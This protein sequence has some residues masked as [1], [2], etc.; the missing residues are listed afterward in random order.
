MPGVNK[1]QNLSHKVNDKFT[2]ILPMKYE[3]S[4]GNNKS[5]HVFTDEDFFRY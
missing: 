5:L 4:S 1:K 3:K 2:T